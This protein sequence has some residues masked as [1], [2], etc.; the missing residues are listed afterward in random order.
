VLV[1]PVPEYME[2]CHTSLIAAH[3]LAIDQAGPHL[4][5]VHGR[6]H[7]RIALRPV[8]TSAGD[9]TDAHRIAPAHQPETVVLDLVNPVGADGGLSARDGRQGSMNLVSAAS[10]LRIRSINMALIRSRSGGSNRNAPP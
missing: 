10:R 6:R 1:S 7:Q 3:Y 9:Q 2:G 8:V 4:E 5:V